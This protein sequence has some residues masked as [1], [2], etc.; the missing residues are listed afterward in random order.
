MNVAQYSVLHVA[1]VTLWLLKHCHTEWRRGFDS[2]FPLFSAKTGKWEKAFLLSRRKI[3]VKFTSQTTYLNIRTNL[4]DKKRNVHVFLGQVDLRKRLF[5]KLF[6]WHSILF[7]PLHTS[8]LLWES[9]FLSV[10]LFLFASRWLS[11]L[12]QRKV[13]YSLVFY[14]LPGYFLN[15]IK[16]WPYF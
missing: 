4:T 7:L 9:C 6:F 8:F 13:H 1:V 3:L 2:Q 15:V 11:N 14:V 10:F 12:S 5:L 16:C